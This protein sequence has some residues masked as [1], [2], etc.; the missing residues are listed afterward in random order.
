MAVH[1]TMIQPLARQKGLTELGNTYVLTQSAPNRI[2][3][4]IQRGDHL[5]N[6]T[7]ENLTSEEEMI[8]RRNQLEKELMDWITPH[9]ETPH[10]TTQPV[11]QLTG[12][13]S[14]SGS[15]VDTPNPESV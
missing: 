9:T 12:S 6:D 1:K 7:L 15:G 13:D 3:L 14:T 5:I 8:E 2:H 10:E 4:T 11:L